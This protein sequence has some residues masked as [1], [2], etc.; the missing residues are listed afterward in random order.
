MDF[1]RDA[2]E[3]GARMGVICGT[4][5][6]PDDGVWNSVSGMLGSELSSHVTPFTSGRDAEK[7]KNSDEHLESHIQSRINEARCYCV[8]CLSTDGMPNLRI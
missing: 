7:P 8:D 2:I 4:L 5:S 3:A 1:L 6:S